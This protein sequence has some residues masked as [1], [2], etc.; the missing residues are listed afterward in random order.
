MEQAGEKKVLGVSRNVFFLGWVSLLTDVS[1]EMI[2]TVMPLFLL[3]VLKVG[4]PIIGLIEGIAEGTASLLK[5]VSGWLSDRLG[6]RKSLAVFGYSLSTLV[7]PFLYIASSWGVVL[8]VRFS[9]RVG[10]GIRSAPRD[11]LVAD[12]TSPNEMGRS[13]GFHRAMDTMGAVLGLSLAA[14][15]VYLVE[16]GG[17]ELTWHAF[18]TLVI[19][20]IGPAVLAVLML[21]L[22]VREKKR[23][24]QPKSGDPT[25]GQAICEGPAK[26]ADGRFKLFLVIMVLF[27]LGNSSDAFLILR[28][29]N[30]GFSVVGLLVLFVAFNLVYA[31][32]AMPAGMVSDK[33]GR[34][35]VIVVGWAIYAL[36]YLGLALASA[37]WQLW[38]LFALYG[39]YYGISEGVCRAFVCDLVPVE[40]RGT[41]YGWYHTAVGISLLPASVIA[42]WLWHLIGPSATFYFGAGMAG[43][44]M[45]GFLL[46]IRE[47]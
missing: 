13:F 40:R 9:D 26:A 36:S 38:L 32:A 19:A 34:K 16:R 45:L 37:T 39:L 2:F 11:A 1:S 17:L 29:Q 35:R 20:G 44:A 30:L 42:G 23:A 46:L 12:S 21:L 28:A 25:A 18:R 41:A 10:K 47:R 5:L 3:N 33:L 22:F 24:A 31:L 6:Q 4:T 14:L 7:K 8:A 27:T 15:I 43:V